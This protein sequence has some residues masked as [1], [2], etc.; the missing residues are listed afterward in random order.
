MY[1]FLSLEQ[2]LQWTPDNSKLLGK[3]KKVLV[4]VI[5]SSKQITEN[6]E[7]DVEG[8]QLSCPPPLTLIFRPNWGPKGRKKI[9][10]TGAPLPLSQGLDDHPPPPTFLKVWIRYCNAPDYIQTWLNTLFETG[11]T[12]WKIKTRNTRLFWNKWN[13]C[14]VSDIITLFFRLV[15]RLKHGLSYRAWNDI[16]N[17]F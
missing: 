2:K 13:K 9:L 14:N 8:I 11:L 3:S 12:E 6:K 7:M 4:R 5:W 15:T 1:Q 10:E 17:E 16:K